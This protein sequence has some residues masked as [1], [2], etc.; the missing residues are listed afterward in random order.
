LPDE[1]NLIELGPGRGT[2][3]VDVMR[4]AKVM[5]RFASSA[6]IHL[7]E[8]SPALRRI[9]EGTFGATASWHAGLD[10][11]PEGPSILIA[12]EFFDA[13]RIR[14]F[15]YRRRQWK[16]R[17]VGL[18]ADRRLALG[19]VEC[20]SS[21]APAREG[22]IVE[23]SPQRQAIARAIGARLAAWPGAALIIDYG[24]L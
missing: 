14:Q 12:N 4:A 10:T 3:M 23:M 17:C 13:I 7:V 1:I 19:L 8:T 24:H 20:R 15:E 5:P 21:L 2:L 11:L 6:R 18:D 22:V 16:E 9:Q